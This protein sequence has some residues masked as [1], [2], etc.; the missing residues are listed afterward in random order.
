MIIYVKYP[1]ELA[2]KLL[3]LIRRF[4]MAAGVKVNTRKSVVFLGSSNEQLKIEM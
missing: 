2:K 4:S 1:E 3:Q